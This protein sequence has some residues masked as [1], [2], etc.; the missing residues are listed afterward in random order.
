MARSDDLCAA[1]VTLIT[2]ASSGDPADS[3][4]QGFIPE[5]ATVTGRA[6]HVFS[7]PGTTVSQMTRAKELREFKVSVVVINRYTDPVDGSAVEVIPESWV[8]EQKTWVQDY[9]FD[10]LNAKAVRPLSMWPARCEL[11]TEV[12]AQQLKDKIFWSEVEIDYREL[13]DN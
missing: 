3:I 2:T 6:V 4:E 11:V 9:V 1:I 8:Q 5:H 7:L 13:S 12:D 10:L